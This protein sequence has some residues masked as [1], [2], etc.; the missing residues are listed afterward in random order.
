MGT[1]VFPD[2]AL[3][4]FLTASLEERATRRFNQLKEKG[5]HANLTALVEELRERDRRDEERVVAPLKR[6][7][8]AILIET[9]SLTINQV[10]DR[11]LE[12]FYLK[13][14]VIQ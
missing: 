9:D 13:H 3:K 14:E 4:V 1:V 5:M 11:I 10:V 8:D 6:A 7:D 2:A 12:F